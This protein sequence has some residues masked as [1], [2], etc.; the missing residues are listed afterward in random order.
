MCTG[1]LHIKP[2]GVA[3][4]QH[5]HGEFRFWE[6]VSWAKNEKGRD[7]CHPLVY[8]ALGSHANYPKPEVYSLSNQFAGSM[9]RLAAH[10]ENLIQIFRT[11]SRLVE[12]HIREVEKA[13]EILEDKQ[14]AGIIAQGDRSEGGSR[15]FA[16]GDGIRVGYGFD[17]KLDVYKDE[18][19]FVIAPPSAIK[20]RESN[21]DGKPAS[22]ED[23]FEDWGFEVIDDD[24]D[25]VKYK[26]LWGRKS[27]V[28]GESGPQGPKWD[29][30]GDVR[31]RWE[32]REDEGHYLEWLDVLL[33]DIVQDDTK[34]TKFRKRA[35]QL[36][37]FSHQHKS[38]DAQ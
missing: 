21:F 12:T 6:D 28:E 34:S 33:L 31:V 24:V 36:I 15:E 14:R 27:N 7:T 22:Q 19:K 16:C 1:K 4:S 23:A 10:L 29:G 2:F 17:P 3:Y 30:K 11:R 5:Y 8:A 20:R 9:Q 25:W 18:L 35:I 32:D 26:G 38:E 37:T 13:F